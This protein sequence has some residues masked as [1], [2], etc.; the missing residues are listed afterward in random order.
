MS[1]MKIELKAS[2]KPSWV[3][4][5]RAKV[6]KQKMPLKPMRSDPMKRL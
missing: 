4:S 1:A 2:A 5:V 6:E 3:L